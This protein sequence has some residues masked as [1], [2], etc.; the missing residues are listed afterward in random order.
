MK[1]AILGGG[2]FIGSAITDRLLRDGHAIRIFERPRVEPY[3]V[4]TDDEDVDWVASTTLW[5][6]SATL[7]SINTLSR[8]H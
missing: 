8:L 1:I 3:R 5:P 2:G 6:V 7:A 4:F